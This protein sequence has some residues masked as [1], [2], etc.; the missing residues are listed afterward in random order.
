MILRVGSLYYGIDKILLLQTPLNIEASETIVTY[1]YKRVVGTD[2]FPRLWD[3]LIMS[4]WFYFVD[5][6]SRKIAKTSLF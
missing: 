5:E 1:V 2:W 4:V 3:C 6:L